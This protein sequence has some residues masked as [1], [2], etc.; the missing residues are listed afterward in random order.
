M[1]DTSKSGEVRVVRDDDARQ[2]RIEVGGKTAGFTAFR[3]DGDR[4][5]F[6]HTELDPAY[7]GRGLGKVLVGEAMADVAKRGETAVPVCPYV[8]KY[9]HTTEVPGLAIDW[10]EQPGT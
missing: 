4:L 3:R 1:T 7:A 5:R 8:V 10:S 9:L 2:Y 6:V